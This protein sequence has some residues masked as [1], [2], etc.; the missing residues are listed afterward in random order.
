MLPLTRFRSSPRS[1]DRLEGRGGSNNGSF[2]ADIHDGNY[3]VSV[4]PPPRG[5][6]TL[7]EAALA[8]EALVALVEDEF[9][10]YPLAEL[11][12]TWGG[13]SLGE[14]HYSALRKVEAWLPR[15]TESSISEGHCAP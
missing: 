14:A 5:A 1:P 10:R 9:P 11:A 3:A 12:Y 2:S 7:K 15:D 4:E 6:F 13:S 8:I